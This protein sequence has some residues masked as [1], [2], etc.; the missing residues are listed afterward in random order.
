[1]QQSKKYLTS[2]DPK[3]PRKYITYLNK[4]NLYGYVMSKSLPMGR[5]KWLDPAKFHLD[6]YDNSLIGC[7]LVVDLQYPKELQEFHSDYRLVPKKLEIKKEV[8]SDYQ[9]K[10]ADDCN[11]SICN[12]NKFVP[13]FFGKEKCVVLH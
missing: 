6:K 5:F 8:L 9:L 3:K 7:V 12:V 11:I 13:N 10:I 4:N 1:M 2:Y